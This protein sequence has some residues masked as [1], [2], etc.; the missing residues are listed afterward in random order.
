MAGLLSFIL[1]S[2]LLTFFG[3]KNTVMKQTDGENRLKYASMLRMYDGEGYS[4][5]E[6]MT[7]GDTS[8]VMKRYVMVP[9]DS[10]VPTDLPEGTLI[11]TPLERMTV[12][13]TIYTDAFD[14]LGAVGNVA[15]VVDAQFVNTPAVKEG[16]KT[17]KVIDCGSSTA[18]T[19]ER[20]LATRGDGIVYCQ[21][22]GMDITGI[23][24][25]GLPLITM[26]DNYETSPLGRAEWILFLGELVGKR[27]E[28]ESQFGAIAAEYERVRNE[29]SALKHRPKVMTDNLFQGVWYVPG[30]RSYQA[31]LIADAG[32]DYIFADD[33]NI[34]SLNLSLEEMLSRS[35]D[36]DVW[37]MRSV[38]PLTTKADLLQ[39]DSRYATF[40]PFKKGNVFVADGT[41]TDVFSLAAFHPDVMLKEYADIFR[42]VAS[43]ESSANQAPR[44]YQRLK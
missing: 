42:W 37:I 9:S 33:T 2:V 12:F 38:T 41:K 29:A 3:P 21:Y 18:P 36:A 17:G 15:G 16:L 10:D 14:D 39:T 23:D 44:I 1:F 11:R 28:A 24:R 27:T 32:G 30:G 34:G 25:L 13:S 26:I 4:V 7:P 6:L 31:R 43:P 5:A 19:A 8:K 20:I 22:E 35:K 40:P